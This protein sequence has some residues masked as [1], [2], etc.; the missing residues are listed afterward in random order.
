MNHAQI[1]ISIMSEI[2]EDNPEMKFGELLYSMTRN[3]LTG[4]NINST[5]AF[6]KIKDEKWYDIT[7]K[8]K[9]DEQNN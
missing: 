7:E 6:T 3:K 9:K 8:V 2:L 4:L 5:H 1:V